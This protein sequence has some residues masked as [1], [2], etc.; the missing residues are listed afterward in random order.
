MS[1][2]SFITDPSKW[3]DI[4]PD[5]YDE[6]N[7]QIEQTFEEG[8][9]GDCSSCQSDCDHRESAQ[10]PKFAKRMYAVNGGKGGAGKSSVTVLLAGELARRGLKVGVL[11]CDIYTAVI[12]HMMGLQGPVHRGEGGAPIPCKTESGIE[13]MS[14]DLILDKPMDPVLWPGVDAF[15]IL[16][17]LYTSTA[18][19]DLDVMLLD[20]PS[21]CGDIPLNLYTTFPVDG[22][23][24]VTN[25]GALSVEAVQRCINLCMMLMSPTVAYVENKSFTDHPVSQ[26]AYVLPHGCVTVS[27]PLSG[28]ITALGEDGALEGLDCPEL[29]PVADV[30]VTAVQVSARKEKK[31]QA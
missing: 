5:M 7:A 11:D 28:D 14:I 17:Y 24:A 1:D 9:H 4:T 16:N 30:I 18:W 15:N 26:D 23:I 19:G 21:G 8:C 27:V 2:L 25:P 10:L 13:V 6:I 29:K 31:T 22:T 20:M 12:P 3:K